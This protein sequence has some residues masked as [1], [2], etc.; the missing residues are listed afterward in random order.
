MSEVEN[1]SQPSSPVPEQQTQ[2]QAVPTP[3]PLRRRWETPVYI[4]AAG[5]WGAVFGALVGGLP[6]A[7]VGAAVGAGGS[8]LLLLI[9]KEIGKTREGL[10]SS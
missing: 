5:G 4:T 3:R 2:I 9:A 6:G 7:A 8:S 1:G 10:R